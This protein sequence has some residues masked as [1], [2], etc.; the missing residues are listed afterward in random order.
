MPTRIERM[1]EA[2]QARRDL[3]IARDTRAGVAIEKAMLQEAYQMAR[4]NLADEDQ[5]A[6]ADAFSASV[7]LGRARR[8]VAPSDRQP[9]NE[10][11]YAYQG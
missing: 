1:I 4:A 3:A 5:K 10:P 9:T 8:N 6:S 7:R 11:A 2:K